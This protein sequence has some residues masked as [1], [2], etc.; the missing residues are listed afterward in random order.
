MTLRHPPT[1]N[2]PHC[3]LQRTHLN[4]V[5]RNITILMAT[6]IATSHFTF[7]CFWTNRQRKGT[8]FHT[9][10]T[11]LQSIISC[12]VPPSRIQHNHQ[13]ICTFHLLL[14]EGSFGICPIKSALW[15]I[16]SLFNAI[17][18]I[19]LLYYYPRPLVSIIDLSLAPTC[20]S[21]ALAKNYCRGPIILLLLFIELC[22][23]HDTGEVFNSI[24]S[25]IVGHLSVAHQINYSVFVTTKPTTAAVI[26]FAK[27]E[28]LISRNSLL[29]LQ[30]LQGLP[31]IPLLPTWLPLDDNQ[32]VRCA[33]LH[34]SKAGLVCPGD[35]P[36]LYASS[37][38]R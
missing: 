3:V 28:K 6:R 4:Y 18:Q 35:E 21:F 38:L 11:I 8:L 36:F 29:L 27:E 10:S 13:N 30:H 24:P 32:M 25:P 20:D 9:Q 19:P 23:R 14:L 2:H 26:R 37:L 15:S 17:Q 16:R 33:R 31:S 5:S 12:C 22:G 1:R 34:K 7:N